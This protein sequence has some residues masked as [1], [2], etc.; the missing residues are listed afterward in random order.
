[1][2]AA[3]LIP[4]TPLTKD[5]IT[6][7][8]HSGADE[9]DDWLHNYAWVNHQS[10]NA[11]VFVSNRGQTVVGYY[12]LATAGV[13]KTHAPAE[14]T[15][16][17]VPTQISCLLLA[18]LA[19]DKSEQNRGLGRGML[20]DAIRR[21]VRVSDDVGVRALLIHARDDDAR[22]FYEHHGEFVPSPTDPLHL[23]L[24]IKQARALIQTASSN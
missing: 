12:A 19:V 1:M 20:V 10:G 8:F 4:P 21:V 13:E 3:P 14:L 15:K 18:R 23:F 5:H 9:L 24:H 22:R 16:G 2:S 17:G 6:A 11:R 7:E